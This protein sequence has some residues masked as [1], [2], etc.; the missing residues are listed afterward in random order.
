MAEQAM[1]ER[2]APDTTV[3]PAIALVAAVRAGEVGAT[4][5]L[6][7]RYGSYVERILVRLLGQHDPDLEDLLHEVFIECFTS[8]DRLVDPSRFKPWLAQIAVFTA[9]TA[10]RRRKRKRWLTFLA[11]WD[12]PERASMPTDHAQKQLVDRLYRALDDL[13][14]DDRIAFSLRF[15]EQMTVA[16]AAEITG[17]SPATLKRRLV[18]ARDNLRRALGV[19]LPIVASKDGEESP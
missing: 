14:P 12:V 7:D 8:L 17:V 5:A 2:I 16:E 6:F 13:A 19:E 1:E 18:R 10:I 11:P 9:R 4:A 15:L 3:E